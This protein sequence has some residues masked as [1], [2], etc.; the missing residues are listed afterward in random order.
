MAVD[1]DVEDA[2]FQKRPFDRSVF[3]A[4]MQVQVP[5]NIELGRHRRIWMILGAVEVVE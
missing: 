1:M 3:F 4:G 5:A 2:F